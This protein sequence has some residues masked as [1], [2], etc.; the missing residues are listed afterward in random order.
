[1]KKAGTEGGRSERGKTRR[2]TRGRAVCG[3]F[4]K[5]AS[6]CAAG[7]SET[8]NRRQGISREAV[9]GIQAEVIE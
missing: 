8:C 2:K 5:T 7:G 6:G 3:P 9:Q 4:G 1:M